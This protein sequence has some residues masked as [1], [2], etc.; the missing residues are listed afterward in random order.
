MALRAAD[1]ARLV[2]GELAGDPDAVVSGVA[3]IR[4]AGPGDVTFLSS[5]K[6]RAA[7]AN[8]R[9]A[10]IIAGRD[11]P[12]NIERTVIRVDDPVAAFTTVVQHFMPP[13]LTVTPG[14]DPRAVIAPSATLGS[15]VTVQAHAVIEDGATVGDRCVIGAGCYIGHGTRIGANCRLEPRVTIREHVTIGQRVVIH[16]GAVIGSD[17]FGFEVVQGRHERLP[18]V[19]TVDIGDDVEIGAN[20]VIDRARFGRTRI[21]RGT[22]I[23]SL[24]MIAH[25]CIIGEDCVICGLSGLAGSV[26][27]G[28]RVTL[29]GQVGVAGHLTIGDGSIIMAKSGVTKDVPP[30]TLMLGAPAVPH[31]E[32]KRVNAALQRLPQ[33]AEKVRELD[34]QLAQL[35][36]E[37]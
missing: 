2:G 18:H 13:P 7:L 28:N 35:Q 25:N 31:R 11:V 16:A 3:G 33:L 1:I 32:F 5:P 15:G 34:R 26:I 4:E 27:L 9:A 20:T 14:V 8:T 10:V 21:G 6:Y 12:V 24:V 29:A 23:D 37:A 22:K 19:G 36:A 17:G 30:N